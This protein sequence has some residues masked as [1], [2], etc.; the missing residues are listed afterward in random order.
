MA[1]ADFQR[2]KDIYPST[3]MDEPQWVAVF[4][5]NP[6]IMWHMVGDLYSA[7]RDE[8]DH[9]AGIRRVGRRPARTSASL[10]DVW[11][12]VFPTQAS[13]DPFVEALGK[14]IGTRSIRAFALKVPC[15]YS[16]LSRLRGGQ[17]Q[18]DMPMMES[19]AKAGKVPPSFFL[20]W[21]AMYVGA[22]MTRVLTQRPNLSVTALRAI[23]T[24]RAEL[25]RENS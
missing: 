2:A 4:D 24:G 8:E 15:H 14:L 9:E 10:E 5:R 21:R 1:K 18:P 20:E 13:M 16:T 22:L 7:V 19:I 11:A 23:N 25:D 3:G 17:L 12:T 6:D